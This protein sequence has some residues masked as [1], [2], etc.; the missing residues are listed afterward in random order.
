MTF[1]TRPNLVDFHTI[2]KDS[3]NVQDN[4]IS[5]VCETRYET[6]Y[7]RNS[8]NLDFYFDQIP[9]SNNITFNFGPGHES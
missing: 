6:Q 5:E 3:S 7:N 4:S 9:K 1:G 2:S 8:N